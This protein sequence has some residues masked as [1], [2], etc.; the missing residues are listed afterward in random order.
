M[1]QEKLMSIIRSI[2][3]RKLNNPQ[4]QTIHVALSILVFTEFKGKITLKDLTELA[5]LAQQIVD[6]VKTIDLPQNVKFAISGDN[7]YAYKS[8][9]KRQGYPSEIVYSRLVF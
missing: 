2:A 6:H 9:P 7:I 4:H 8:A 5:N 1:T 3:L